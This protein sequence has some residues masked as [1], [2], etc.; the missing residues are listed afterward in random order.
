MNAPKIHIFTYGCQ[1]NDY[2]SDR[3][4]RLFNN[5]L[6]YE[7]AETPVDANLVIFN[8]CSIR[9]K[10]DQ[11]A[12]SSLGEL[13]EIKEQRGENLTIAVGGC[14]AQLRGEEL[15][16]RFP[17]VDIVFGTH[18]WNKLPE[19]VSEVQSKK[20][21]KSDL[22]LFGWQS[23]SFL[24]EAGESA[25]TYPVSDLITVQNGCDKFCTFC[26]VPY[27]RGRQVSRNLE[28]IV[29]EAELLASK[30]VR[31]VILLGQNV[32]AYGNDRSS[33][34]GFSELLR[35]VAS[36]ENIWRIRFVTSHP[37]ELSFEMIDTMAELPEVV[38]NLHLPIQSGSNRILEKMNRSY[39]VEKY[40]EIIS[41]LRDKMPDLSLTTDLMVGFPG[42]TEAD[43]ALTLEAMRRFHF[44]ESF[45][46]IY[47][48][49][50]NT[51]AIK[52]K[53]EY[54]P[55]EVSKD[56]LYRLQALQET[57]SHETR[58]TFVG[59]TVE[60]LVEGPAARD[61]RQMTGKMPQNWSVNFEAPASLRGKRVWVKLE[62]K[63]RNTFKGKLVSIENDSLKVELPAA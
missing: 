12:F 31:E 1:M 38:A 55:N 47:S 13:K 60:V 44:E 48:P 46:F 29:K 24:K 52:Y 7:W 14:T 45:S 63:M 51:K 5:Q 20:G 9:E 43:F 27:T 58:K 39:T 61:S 42:E 16:K 26:V 32:N 53:D 37:S 34:L 3:T 56:R 23:Y 4:Y 40:A 10:A 2:E 50:P 11:K 36:V 35:Q 19:L 28:D 49:R 57:L 18:Q 15:Q 30:G 6:G 17:Y 59:K 33:K 21:R 62:E 25:L 41:Y 8:T 54:I 22:D